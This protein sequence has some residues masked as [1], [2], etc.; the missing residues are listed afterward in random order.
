ME[1]EFKSNC[2]I[3]VIACEVVL[4][5]ITISGKNTSQLFTLSLTRAISPDGCM[6]HF[7]T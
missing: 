6:V 2:D 1:Q 4:N 7:Y 5:A 3:S